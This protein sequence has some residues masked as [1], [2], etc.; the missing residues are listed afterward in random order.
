M[1]WL[2]ILLLLLNA[3]LFVW[4]YQQQQNSPQSEASP[5]LDPSEGQTLILQGE[6]KD[7]VVPKPASTANAQTANT[8]TASVPAPKPAKPVNSATQANS[9]NEAQSAVMRCYRSTP[10]NEQIDAKLLAAKIKKLGYQASIES[11]KSKANIPTKYWVY[12]PKQGSNKQMQRF[13][14]RLKQQQ[15]DTFV[16][17]K[18]KFAGGISLGIYRSKKS[19]ESLEREVIQLRIPVNIA[20]I[21][22]ST[23]QYR[24]IFFTPTLPNSKLLEKLQENKQSIRWRRTQCPL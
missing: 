8:P 18:G 20:V 5:L 15:L 11:S 24:V 19:A 14:A 3:A 22:G 2:V 17:H 23:D 10:F 6:R 16:I 13:Q 9:A 4:F 21:D 7:S 12:V 1:R